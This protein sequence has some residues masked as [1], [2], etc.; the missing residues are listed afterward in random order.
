M[1]TI[2]RHRSRRC[3]MESKCDPSC[4]LRSGLHGLD[5]IADDSRNELLVVAFRH[6]ADDG[7]QFPKDG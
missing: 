5:D 7:L 4:G 2:G 3:S 1:R 6:H